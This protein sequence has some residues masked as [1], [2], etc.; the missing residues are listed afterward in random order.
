M[1][2]LDDVFGNVTQFDQEFPH[3][4]GV[5]LDRPAPPFEPLWVT[6]PD[7][8]PVATSPNDTVPIA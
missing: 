8:V 1:D 2:R 4:P 6:F 5:V 7:L 3:L